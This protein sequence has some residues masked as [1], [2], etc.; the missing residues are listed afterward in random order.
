VDIVDIGLRFQ[1]SKK[2]ER[3]IRGMKEEES[4]LRSTMVVKNML[5]NLQSHWEKKAPFME[6]GIDPLQSF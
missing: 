6:L 2:D 3:I 5:K 1:C 4:S